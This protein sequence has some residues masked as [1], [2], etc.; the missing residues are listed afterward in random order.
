VN[1]AE[2]TLN[3]LLSPKLGILKIIKTDKVTITSAIIH[4]FTFGQHEAKA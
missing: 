2:S 4:Q 3:A 1:P